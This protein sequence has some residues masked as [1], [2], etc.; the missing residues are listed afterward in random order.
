MNIVQEFSRFAKQ[1][2]T[3]NIIQSD[4]AK[5]LVSIIDKRDYSSILDIGCGSGLIYKNIVDNNISFK[6]F[7]AV[8]FS[9]EMLDIHPSSK[10]I[11][12]IH[13][14]FNNKK[15]F[16]QLNQ[17]DFVVSS[18]ALQWS[19][20]LDMTIKEISKLSTDCYL[21]FFTS[22]TFS[23]LHKVAGIKSPIY[24]QESIKKTL[25]KYYNCS[26]EIVEYHLSFD[27]VYD[28]FQYIK[29]SGVSGG[30]KI[31]S[32]SQIKELIRSYPLDYLEF[33][34]LFIRGSVKPTTK[35]N[36]P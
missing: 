7:T 6:H 1:Y 15:S 22:N 34:V 8:D 14:D 36:H 21:S 24:S 27:R 23:T 12:K 26:F 28:M 32:Y 33:E 13:F 3:Y 25:S 10:D 5:K 16:E 35:I 11:E 9:M 4:V 31:L 29:K 30:D 18:S 17:Y 20:D 2:D 19:R